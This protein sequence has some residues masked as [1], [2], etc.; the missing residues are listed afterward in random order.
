MV[1]ESGCILLS[2]WPRY[3]GDASTTTESAPP[4]PSESN[5][6]IPW[7]NTGTSLASPS[8]ELAFATSNCL[9]SASSGA[10]FGPHQNWT[11]RTA[12]YAAAAESASNSP[13]APFPVA[14][15]TSQPEPESTPTPVTAEP[16]AEP[17]HCVRQEYPKST[18]G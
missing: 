8:A 3:G 7:S 2:E 15:A 6:C 14:T 16:P 13:T 1:T 12:A 10:C 4:S 5:S 9:E 11:M 17:Q 18:L